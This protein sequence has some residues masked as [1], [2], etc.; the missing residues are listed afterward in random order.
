MW[1]CTGRLGSPLFFCRYFWSCFLTIYSNLMANSSLQEV[2][3]QGA[4]LAVSS[5]SEDEIFRSLEK[6]ILVQSTEVTQSED[7]AILSLGLRIGEDGILKWISSSLDHPRN[8]SSRRKFFDT[9]LLF[10]FD[11][12]TLASTLHEQPLFELLINP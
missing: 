9:L 7:G 2:Q 5:V 1:V 8:W 10:M 4:I 6:A 12:F 11:L 3:K